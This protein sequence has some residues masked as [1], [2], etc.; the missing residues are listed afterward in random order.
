MQGEGFGQAA[1][2]LRDGDIEAAGLSGPERRLLDFVETITLHAYRVTDEQVQGLRDAGWSDE[3]IAE[4][5]YDAALFNLFVRL[6]DTFGIEPPVMY[7]PDGV[8]AA[9]KRG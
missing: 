2:A 4:A 7:E 3:Q 8:P 9:A 1:Q 5:A 6:A